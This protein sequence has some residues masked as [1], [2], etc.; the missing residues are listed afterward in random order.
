LQSPDTGKVDTVFA[1][2]TCSVE[3]L[4]QSLQYGLQESKLMGRGCSIFYI[5]K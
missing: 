4:M 3:I 2:K 5:E 1:R